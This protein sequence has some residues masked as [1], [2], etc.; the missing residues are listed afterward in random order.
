MAI[1]YLEH[2]K[3]LLVKAVHDITGLTGGNPV[4]FQTAKTPPH[5][6]LSRLK[7]S[8]LLKLIEPWHSGYSVSS[9]SLPFLRDYVVKNWS[10]ILKAN[11][12]E[13]QHQQ[14]TQHLQQREGQRR[15]EDLQLDCFSSSLK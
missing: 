8:T 7:E 2:E 9:Q 10:L 6:A 5:E 15:I 3:H 13:T 1:I 11:V 12:K 4:F 14:Q